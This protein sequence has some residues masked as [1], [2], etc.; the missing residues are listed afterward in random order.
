MTLQ[1]YRTSASSYQDSKFFHKEKRILEGIQGVKYITSLRE[2]DPSLPV[3]LITNT[4]TIPEEISP[5]LLEKTCLIIHPNSGHDN[6]KKTFVTEMNFPIVI[7]NP[8]RSHAVVEYILGCIFQHFTQIPHHQH[9]SEDRTWQRKLLRDQKVTILGHGHI[10]KILYQ[11][12]KPLCKE[13]HVFDP[14]I[15]KQIN[16]DIHTQI[17]DST[18]KDTQILICAASLNPSSHHL[19]NQRILKLLANDVLLI[20]PARGGIIQEEDLIQYL[21]QNPKSYAFLDVFESEPFKP[22]LYNEVKNLNKTSHIA[23]V[24]EKLNNDIIAFEYIIIEDFLNH[25]NQNTLDKFVHLNKDCVL[26]AES[27]IE[28]EYP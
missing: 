20:N 4:H 22:G 19:I 10:G 27:F 2:L 7:G 8:I 24:H 21:Q 15:E 13:L 3:V 11:V 6:L 23:G 12:I 26:R 16:P 17:D 28:A 14:F 18:F 5:K 9:W 1:I 25:K